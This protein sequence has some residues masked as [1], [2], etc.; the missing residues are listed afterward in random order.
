[1]ITLRKPTARQRQGRAAEK[2]AQR[3]LQQQGLRKITSNYHCRHG[4][5]D[6]IMR[7]D[8]AL[9]FV[10]VRYRSQTGHGHGFDSIDYHKQ[11][12]LLQAARHYLAR[13]PRWLN[14]PCRFDVISID[15]AME[16][17]AVEWISN[18]IMEN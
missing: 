13:H 1:M 7:D 12:R 6:L 3:F 18:A 15:G 8:T 16:L 9:V 14:R 2:L 4:E 5:I 17:S 11:Q 10:E